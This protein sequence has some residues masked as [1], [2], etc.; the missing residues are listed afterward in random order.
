VQARFSAT[1]EILTGVSKGW[2]QCQLRLSSI[3]QMPL[4]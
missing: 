2:R 4:V 1:V 3:I